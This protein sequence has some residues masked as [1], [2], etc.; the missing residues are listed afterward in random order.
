M[1]A[2]SQPIDLPTVDPRIAEIH[3]HRTKSFDAHQTIKNVQDRQLQVCRLAATGLD[4]IDVAEMTGY[5]PASVSRIVNNARTAG[6][7]QALRLEGDEKVMEAKRVLAE[8]AVTIAQMLADAAKNEDIAWRDRRHIMDSV[9][10]RAGVSRQSESKNTTVESKHTTIE[11]IRALADE[12]KDNV[13]VRAYEA[14]FQV[15]EPE[16]VAPQLVEQ[17]EINF[18]ASP[19]KFDDPLLAA[20]CGTEGA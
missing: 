9:L 17:L 7:M 5:H 13:N 11:H 14:Q 10:D 20:V 4:H 19:E 12:T 18:V 16:A 15:L 6:Y 8:E 1:A 3:A 2:M